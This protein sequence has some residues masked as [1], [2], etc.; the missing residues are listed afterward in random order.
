MTSD[1]GSVI[2]HD[3]PDG[4]SIPWRDPTD[5]TSAISGSASASTSQAAAPGV[6]IP[7]GAASALRAT[8]AGR[9]GSPRDVSGGLGR[10]AS[11]RS[12]SVTPLSEPLV[13]GLTETETETETV[14]EGQGRRDGKGR[15]MQG[16]GPSAGAAADTLEREATLAKG[17]G[18]LE[19]VLGE[20]LGAQERR[21]AAAG[22][23]AP[24]GQ[25]AGGTE[26]G[27]R[28]GQAAQP[29]AATAAVQP[30]G[31]PPR[32]PSRR[33]SE[34]G[35]TQQHHQQQQQGHQTQHPLLPT[36][37]TG[38]SSSSRPPAPAP[39][40]LLPLPPLPPQPQT[41]SLAPRAATEPA[42][43][44]PSTNSPSVPQD[45]P[46]APASPFSATAAPYVPSPFAGAAAGTPT[47]V[48]PTAAAAAPGTCAVTLAA[49]QLDPGV[50]AALL[51]ELAEHVLTADIG[52]SS[53][54]N[55]V[56]L[57]RSLAALQVGSWDWGEAGERTRGA[58]VLSHR[59]T[60]SAWPLAASRANLLCLR[61]LYG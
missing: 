55:P 8:A 36:V 20:E 17:M 25:G 42:A 30:L 45:T 56:R 21:R 50:A 28:Q 61:F 13:G 31:L 10:A 2:V 49:E 37:S 1:V 19:A 12:G 24:A 39:A 46:A 22:V 27:A 3:D 14:G 60:A 34:P 47:S 16:A 52:F 44:P 58:A 38:A 53:A 32:P 7:P 51:E 6:R 43:H 11:D 26:E 23:D 59:H 41:P 18:E 5:N 35:A 29:A 54:A 9:R 48:T 33:P 40:A 57:H 4:L 15:G